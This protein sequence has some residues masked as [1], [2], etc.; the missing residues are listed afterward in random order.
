MALF[1][2]IQ[3]LNSAINGFNGAQ[4]GQMFKKDSLTSFYFHGDVKPNILHKKVEAAL[5][6][7]KV[8]INQ[9]K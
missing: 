4:L 6:K 7:E 5:E 1:Q 3:Q 9:L 8:C 2:Y